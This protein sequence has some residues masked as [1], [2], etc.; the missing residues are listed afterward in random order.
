M[1]A[2][3]FRGFTPAP[4]CIRDELDMLA[5]VV[6]GAVWRFGQ[7][8]GGRCYASVATIAERAGIGTTATRARLG[9]L[10]EHGWIESVVRPGRP[11]VYRDAGRW[12]I[13]ITGEDRQAEPQR[14]ALGSRRPQRQTL[15]TPTPNVGVPQRQTLAKIDTLREDLRND[16]N[17][18]PAAVAAAAPAGADAG[19]PVTDES[20]VPVKAAKPP[21][22]TAIVLAHIEASIGGTSLRTGAGYKAGVG[23]LLGDLGR[24]T[25][26]D[27][28][29]A[30]ALWSAF[31]AFKTKDGP[32]YLGQPHG[33]PVA[34]S[35]WRTL[36]GGAVAA[37]RPGERGSPM[38]TDADERYAKSLR[39][40]FETGD[41]SLTEFA[42]AETAYIAFAAAKFTTGDM[43]MMVRAR[44]TRGTVE[45]RYAA[46]RA[47]AAAARP[48]SGA[49]SLSSAVTA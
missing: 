3:T 44:L 35:T 32:Q 39:A 2:E 46:A 48:P 14:L 1:K 17:T 42:A 27:A 30:C 33:W 26:D 43:A 5:A 13:T 8:S 28:A 49:P 19:M 12:G 10:A 11:T 25:G 7:Q 41:C 6:F 40:K 4:D 29:A 9:L 22:F 16:G 20:V 24:A 47:R 23:Q 15:A 37:R 18:G 34:F 31:V 36:T 38:L 21:T 45:Q